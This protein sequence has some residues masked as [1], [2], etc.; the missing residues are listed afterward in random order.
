[1]SDL[2]SLILN[3]NTVLSKKHVVSEHV[4]DT[5]CSLYMCQRGLAK[6]VRLVKGQTHPGYGLIDRLCSQG[7]DPCAQ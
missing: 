1:M 5:T 6:C 2:S 7:F 4:A 3:K